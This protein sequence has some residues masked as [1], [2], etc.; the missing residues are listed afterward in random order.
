M[1]ETSFLFNWESCISPVF[2][3]TYAIKTFLSLPALH[4][5]HS[6]ALSKCQGSLPDTAYQ[7]RP[8][9]LFLPLSYLWYHLYSSSNP[10]KSRSLVCFLPRAS[11]LSRQLW[12]FPCNH[13]QITSLVSILQDLYMEER[14]PFLCYSCI[15][16]FG[17][18]FYI[19]G[20]QL[21]Y[22]SNFKLAIWPL[23]FSKLVMN[24]IS[25]Q[26][27]VCV[28]VWQGEWQRERETFLTTITKKR[29]SLLV[30][31][32]FKI[33]YIIYVSLDKYTPFSHFRLKSDSG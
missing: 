13:S 32:T 25:H 23:Q 8:K 19:D 5:H 11:K 3:I 10:P 30:K 6:Y 12:G 24:Y 31:H 14:L 21:E 17:P 2:A 4:I 20:S 22:N 26:N 16:G 29:G 1:S 27:S 7:K 28:Y 18:E 9:L 33:K 15:V